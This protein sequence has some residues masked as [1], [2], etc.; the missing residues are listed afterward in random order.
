MIY[1]DAYMEKVD[2]FAWHARHKRRQNKV[3]EALEQET[4]QFEPMMEYISQL[5]H[6]LS[7]AE[8]SRTIFQE[9]SSNLRSLEKVLAVCKINKEEP[10]SAKA[11]GAMLGAIV[12]S[13]IGL[14]VLE[15]IPNYSVLAQVASMII[16]TSSG[17]VVGTGIG[18]VTAGATRE[19]V[20]LVLDCWQCFVYSQLLKFA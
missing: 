4:P 8:D 1:S 2:T 13:A 5:Q 7:Q 6:S 12:G 16:L 20:K 15:A 14:A 18:I 19:H 3:V 9:F 11:T 17:A 10:K